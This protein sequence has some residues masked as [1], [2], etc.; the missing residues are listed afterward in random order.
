MCSN[1]ILIGSMK[2]YDT[3]A[4][5]VVKLLY[6]SK[7]NIQ[8]FLTSNDRWW[9]LRY[10]KCVCNGCDKVKVKNITEKKKT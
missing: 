9:I 3:I 4:R 7:F 6:A 10:E 2:Q 8:M 1:A 5:I